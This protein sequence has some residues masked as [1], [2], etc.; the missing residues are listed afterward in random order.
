M[1]REAREDEREVRDVRCMHLLSDPLAA[2]AV[3]GVGVMHDGAGA[4]MRVAEGAQRMVKLVE[5]ELA[6]AVGL[7]WEER[8]GGGGEEMRRGGEEMRGGG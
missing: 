4:R 6:V 1:R 7:Q 5:C 2:D 8:K 3:G